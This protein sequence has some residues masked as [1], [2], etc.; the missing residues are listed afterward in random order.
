MVKHKMKM[1]MI[2]EVLCLISNGVIRT[3][4]MNVRSSDKITAVQLT[5]DKNVLNVSQR[6]SKLILSDFNIWCCYIM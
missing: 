1:L 2:N 5:S 4:K 3:M 6:V